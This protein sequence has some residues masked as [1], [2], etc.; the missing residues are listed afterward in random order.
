MRLSVRCHSQFKGKSVGQGHIHTMGNAEVNWLYRCKTGFFHRR[1]NQL[2]FQ[3]TKFTSMSMG[4]NH[5]HAFSYLQL[6]S[7][8]TA[9]RPQNVQRPHRIR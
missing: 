8:K 2:H 4:K 7:C 5:L 1:G 3:W 9:Q 6:T